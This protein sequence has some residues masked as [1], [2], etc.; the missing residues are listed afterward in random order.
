[1]IGNDYTEECLQRKITWVLLK[2]DTVP[3]GIKDVCKPFNS[4]DSRNVKMSNMLFVVFYKF[5]HISHKIFFKRLDIENTT[6]I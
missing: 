1:M 6:L 4:S 2:I 3:A 5:I